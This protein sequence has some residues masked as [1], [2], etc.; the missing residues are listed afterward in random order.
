MG[1]FF[2]FIY[3]LFGVACAWWLWARAQKRGGRP[4]LITW[5]FAFIWYA[6]LGM[7]LSFT[8]INW[9]DYHS[10]AG[11]VGFIGTLVVSGGLG[12]VVYR[13]ANSKLSGRVS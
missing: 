1:S 5:V 3:A 12:F 11:W 4:A 10:Q 13:L 8:F 7:G 6:I 2:V 9:A